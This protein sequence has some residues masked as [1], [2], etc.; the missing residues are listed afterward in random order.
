MTPQDV[1]VFARLADSVPLNTPKTS[2]KSQ[3]LQAAHLHAIVRG[4][5]EP[6][7]QLLLSGRLPSRAALCC[8]HCDDT[9][10]SAFTAA[11]QR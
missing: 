11:K 2:I 6:T 8:N 4:T 10:R 3:E 9:R 1:T 7:R 5:R